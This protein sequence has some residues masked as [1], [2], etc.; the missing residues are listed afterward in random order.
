MRGQQ[1]V[2][3]YGMLSITLPKTSC[4]YVCVCIHTHPQ[5]NF[6]KWVVSNQVGST[7]ATHRCGRMLH[8]F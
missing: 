1:N 3:I 6:S 7:E 4:M 2:I 8:V 5:T